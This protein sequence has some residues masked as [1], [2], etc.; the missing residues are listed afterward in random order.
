M[1]AY[2]VY[3][4]CYRPNIINVMVT[5]RGHPK[6]GRLYGTSGTIGRGV[7]RVT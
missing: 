3:S 6:G 7:S 1:V 2:R 5:K 4:Y